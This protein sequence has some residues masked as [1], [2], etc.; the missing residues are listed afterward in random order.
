MPRRAIAPSA[1][2]SDLC[3]CTICGRV[4]EYDRRRGHTRKRCNSC[5]SNR[6]TREAR[7]QLKRK[8]VAYKGNRCELCGYDQCLA[9]LSFHHLPNRQKT[10]SIAGNHGHSWAR[11]R[12]ELDKCVLLCQNCHAETH[13]T[14]IRLGVA[15]WNRRKAHI[16]QDEADGVAYTCTT[17]GRRYVHDFRKGHT[18]RTCNSCRSNRGGRAARQTL[19]RRM[20]EYKGGRCEHCGYAKCLRALGFHHRDSAAKRFNIAT[21][22]LRSWDAL[23]NE[24]DVCALLCHNC[25][26]GIHS[27]AEGK[28]ALASVHGNQSYVK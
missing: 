16:A 25:H 11:L 6:G 7:V 27:A 24:L 13:E 1:D 23:R 26:A 28:P 10:F 21:S 18:R 17:C 8:M 2:A 19:K 15:R 12:R 4:Y 22:H 5:G 20:V 14:A 3:A 9:V